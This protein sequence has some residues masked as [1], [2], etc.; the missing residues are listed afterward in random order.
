MATFFGGYCC[1][2]G[3]I[4]CS[5]GICLRGGVW[6]SCGM[7]DIGYWSREWG[8]GGWFFFEGICI[9]GI[10]GDFLVVFCLVCACIGRVGFGLHVGWLGAD[11]FGM[12][13]QGFQVWW[14]FV[15]CG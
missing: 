6:C 2:V 14:V 13:V 3:H 4:G 1:G 11:L 8:V 5:W 12:V 7:W 10:W 9:D 15:V